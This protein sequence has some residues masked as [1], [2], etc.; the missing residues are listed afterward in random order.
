MDAQ[1]DQPDKVGLFINFTHSDS[2]LVW[3]WLFLP[4]PRSSHGRGERQ[5]TDRREEDDKKWKESNSLVDL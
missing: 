5:Q 1:C 3:Q 4:L 2:V